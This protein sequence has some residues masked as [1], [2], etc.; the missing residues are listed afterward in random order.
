MFTINVHLI[1]TSN[2]KIW[3]KKKNNTVKPSQ[4]INIHDSFFLWDGRFSLSVWCL[5][6]NATTGYFPAFLQC[7]PEVNFHTN[8]P[9]NKKI[10][11]TINKK[12]SQKL[13]YIFIYIASIYLS[14]YLCVCM[15]VYVCE[16]SYI[17]SHSLISI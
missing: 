4:N 11:I 17:F 16:Y 3:E 9:S 15:S 6:H 12:F 2:K 14:I 5:F 7:Q 13:I 10:S 8:R 1:Q